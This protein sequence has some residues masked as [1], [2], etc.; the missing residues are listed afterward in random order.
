M[1]AARRFLPLGRHS[2]FSPETAATLGASRH[3]R[4]LLIAVWMVLVLGPSLE[5]SEESAAS[6]AKEPLRTDR[7]VIIGDVDPRGTGTPVKFGAEA[8][9]HRLSQA[10][11]S[12]PFDARP[13]ESDVPKAFDPKSILLEAVVAANKSMR[14]GKGEVLRRIAAA[15]ARAGDLDGAFQT[16]AALSPVQDR[17]SAYGKIAE[18][19]AEAGEDKG[20][21]AALDRIGQDSVADKIPTILGSVATQAKISA[22]RGAALAY[23]RT[24]NVR[25]AEQ[26]LSRIDFGSLPPEIGK[27]IQG[28]ILRELA[29][30]LADR[31]NRRDAMRQIEAIRD[32]RS[33]ESALAQISVKLAENG[34]A[35]GTRRAVALLLQETPP[36]AMAPSVVRALMTIGDRDRAIRYLQPLVKT[37]AQAENGWALR[38]LV[39]ALAMV[40]P[41]GAERTALAMSDKP[42]SSGLSHRDAALAVL[43]RARAKVGDAGGALALVEQIREISFRS[44]TLSA[45]AQSLIDAGEVAQAV[46][47]AAMIE[48]PYWR[49]TLA[50]AQAAAGDVTEALRT[51]ASLPHQLEQSRAL[52][53][54]AKIQGEQGLLEGA[55]RTA[56]GI[57]DES[58]K[59]QVYR[60]LAVAQAK[61][62]RIADALESLD[63][64]AERLRPEAVWQISRADAAG[65]QPGATLSWVRRQNDLY[66]RA[67]AMLGIAE[68]MLDGRT[69][70]AGV[71]EPQR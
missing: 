27:Q 22:L 39:D 49:T 6:D 54:I 16:A 2:A 57:Q 66:E 12:A 43:A 30:I 60:E 37:A 47:A 58:V 67:W 7:A 21:H 53:E 18:V 33:R 61:A 3:G 13:S 11:G 50:K 48:R 34:D 69:D 24:G 41:A 15:Q 56:A 25:A 26:A 5:Q 42:L 36:P 17:L 46:K 38:D 52:A 64:I 70:S 65:R 62:G 8:V 31:N 32:R 51:A 9:Q 68:A 45:V 19:C 71:S 23:G 63:Q 29:L 40:D 28:E 59:S 35:D 55:A 4:R 10:H 14:I 1:T 44:E 20:V